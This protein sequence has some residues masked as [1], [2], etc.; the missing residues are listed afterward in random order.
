M[1]NIFLVREGHLVTPGLQDCGVAGVMRSVVVE[2][3]NRTGAGC[4][5]ETMDAGILDETTELFV[6]NS[7]T[8]IWPVVEI[9]GR[10]RLEIGSTTRELQ[11]ALKTCDKKQPGEWLQS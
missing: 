10:R 11:Q 4:S 1:S 9:A 8:G 5:V 7:L 6:C 3:A 2:L